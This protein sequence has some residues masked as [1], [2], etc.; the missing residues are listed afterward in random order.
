MERS[1]FDHIKFIK[2][3]INPFE[4]DVLQ[5]LEAV[6]KELKMLYSES[7]KFPFT[8]FHEEDASGVCTRDKFREREAG[9]TVETR[10]D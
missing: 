1:V 4:K 6:E 3:R 7:Q 9:E 5:A 2:G 10:K 8:S